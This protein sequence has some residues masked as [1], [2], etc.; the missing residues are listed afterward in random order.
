MEPSLRREHILEQAAILF[1][2]KG[3][4]ATSI[5]DI[6]KSAGIA[7]G[8][9]YLYFQNKRAIFEELLDNL[10]V[11]IK[12]WI[13]VV[14]ISPNAPSV[15]EQLLDNI[16]RVVEL[17]TKNPALL[18]ILLEGAV[19]LDKE[20]DEKLAHFY[21]QITNTVELSLE[22]GQEMGLVRPC[23]AHIA[24]L[25]AIGAMKEVLYDMLRSN[26]GDLDIDTIAAAILDIFSHGVLASGA[27]FP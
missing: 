19:G 17:L 24:A 4:H 18:S 15:R 16:N 1:G 25:I 21:S 8:T 3:Y 5:A 9:F 14:D 11:Q 2:K 6:I 22:H 23:N 10:V 7:R 12:K 27:T 26:D 13:K 20:F